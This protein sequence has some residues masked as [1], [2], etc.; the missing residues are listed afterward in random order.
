M[1][2]HT[3]TPQLLIRKIQT[4]ENP[5]PLKNICNGTFTDIREG[6]RIK[7]EINDH[8][9]VI[10]K[11]KA[12]DIEYLKSLEGSLSEWSSETDEEAYRDL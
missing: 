8:K 2:I 10:Q 9:V 5:H 1:S 12:L 3:I 6:D 4:F 11:V 7:F